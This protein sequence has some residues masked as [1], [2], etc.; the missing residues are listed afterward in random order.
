MKPPDVVV[1]DLEAVRDRLAR[2]PGELTPHRVAEALR[3]TGRPVGD[4]TVLAVY[5]TLRRDVVGALVSNSDQPWHVEHQ[6]V[7]RL[8]SPWPR[9]RTGVAQTRQGRP[10]RS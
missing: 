1:D 6:Y 4:A 3:E 5:E 9:A 10:A 2:A 8:S 7:V